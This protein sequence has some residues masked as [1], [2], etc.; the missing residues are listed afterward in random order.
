[1]SDEDALLS[2]IAAQPAEDTPR[3]V[4]ADWLDEHDQPIR[5]EFIRLQIDI[6]DKQER[7]TLSWRFFSMQ[8][9]ALVERLSEL[10]VKHRQELLG[11]LAGLP[12][13]T[14]VGFERGFA[15]QIKLTVNEFLVHAATLDAARPVVSVAVSQVAARL[16]EFL[17]SRFLRCVTSISLYSPQIVE[18][19]PAGPLAMFGPIN[20]LTR[21]ESLDLSGCGV[22]DADMDHFRE[23]LV[24]SVKELTLAN[25]AITNVGIVAFMSSEWPRTLRDLHLNRNPI[26]DLGAMALAGAW[27]VDSPLDCLTLRH[28]NIGP[29][30]HEALL[31]RF[32]RKVYLSFE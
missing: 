11:S 1:M 18:N 25:N 9:P 10:L 6:A 32:G 14:D 12:F 27:P 26:S 13:A 28:T 3:L 19:R 29:R 23:W 7:E 20:L 8:Y 4:Y 24:P 22:E 16:H 17:N 15:S 30:G 31:A 5:A 21:L 2:A